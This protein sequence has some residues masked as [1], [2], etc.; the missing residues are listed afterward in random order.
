[1]TEWLNWTE[2]LTHT[3]SSQGTQLLL[4]QDCTWRTSVLEKG[5]SG[6]PASTDPKCFF[7]TRLV[8]EGLSSTPFSQSESMELVL[9]PPLFL[10]L[11]FSLHPGRDEKNSSFQSHPSH[12][13]SPSFTDLPGW[14]RQDYGLGRLLLHWPPAD[15][16]VIAKPAGRAWG[17]HSALMP[18]ASPLSMV[19]EHGNHVFAPQRGYVNREPGTQQG[20]YSLGARGHFSPM[21]PC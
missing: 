12:S 5:V 1:M 14:Y 3:W 16:E 2:R 8:T 18:G 15:P 9:V 10:I 7:P 20:I 4:A 13:P 11:S 17:D 21:A 19:R 6:C